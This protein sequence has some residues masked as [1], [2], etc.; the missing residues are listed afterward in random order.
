MLGVLF[1]LRLGNKEVLDLFR[2]D[3]G[4]FWITDVE[5]ILVKRDYMIISTGIQILPVPIF[6]EHPEHDLYTGESAS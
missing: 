3:M 1:Q 5:S 6:E 4:D 2:C